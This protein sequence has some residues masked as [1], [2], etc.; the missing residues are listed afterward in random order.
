MRLRPRRLLWR[1]YWHS[2]TGLIVFAG[3]VTALVFALRDE[4]R[5]LDE[6][7]ARVAATMPERPSPPTQ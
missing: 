3:L 2:L 4:R 1:I 6:L 7:P 5:P